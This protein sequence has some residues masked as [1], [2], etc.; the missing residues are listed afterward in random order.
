MNIGI[1][2]KR[3]FFNHSGLGNYGRRFCLALAKNLPDDKFILYSPRPV[4][5]DNFYLKE[6]LVSNS[7]IETPARKSH[8]LFGGALWRTKF[9]NR[10]LQKDNIDIYYGLSNEIPFGS[11][12]RHI[13]KIVVIHD[14]IFLRYPELYPSIDRIFYRKKTQYACSRAD[15][16]IAAS[17]QTKQ[18]IIDFYKIPETKISV[19]FPCSDQRFYADQVD[20]PDGFFK[21]D[22]K[23]IIS[24]GAITP[25]KNLMKTVEAFNQVK[26]RYDLDLVVVGTAVGLGREYLSKIKDFI[27]ANNLEDRVHFLGNVPYHYVPGLCRKADLMIYPSQFEG[28]G[29][30]IVEGL[31]S[32]IPVITTQ[33]GC[34]PEA[35]GDAAAYVNPE[36]PGQIADRITKIM[37][38]GDLRSEMVEKGI[39]HAKRFT[40]E[41]IEQEI[42]RFHLSI[43]R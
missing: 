7:R 36:N 17:K 1:D 37:D 4:P 34:F 5:A 42:L 12:T 3:I 33:G 31:F 32:K 14:L 39:Q 25:R 10:Q 21:T 15:Y 13:K 40:Q 38:S 18:D 28:F 6:I 8:K 9:I 22:R 2:A 11:C 16:I 20:D 19:L 23:F 29:M 41:N 27:K 43:S 24:I 35:G 30:P 26:D